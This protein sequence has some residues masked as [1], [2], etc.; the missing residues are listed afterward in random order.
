MHCYIIIIFILDVINNNNY[1]ID[2]Q[3]E[4]LTENATLLII[5][6]YNECEEKQSSCNGKYFKNI[7]I[8]F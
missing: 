4:K 1:C 6:S 7:K 5:N 3:K 8:F 2:D